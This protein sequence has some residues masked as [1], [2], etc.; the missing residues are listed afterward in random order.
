MDSVLEA[1]AFLFSE[2]RYVKVHC[3]FRNIRS[4]SLL[5]KMMIYKTVS[6][7]ANSN[8]A[9]EG[10]VALPQDL[11]DS[12]DRNGFKEL[13]ESYILG[14]ST[15]AAYRRIKNTSETKSFLFPQK[16]LRENADSQ[17]VTQLLLSI[18]QMYTKFNNPR[19]FDT[20]SSCV[21]ELLSNF[22]AHAT[23]ESETLFTAEGN[24]QSFTAVIADNAIGI[25]SSL[26]LAYPE[27]EKLPP[28]DVLL[29]AIQK[30]ISSKLKLESKSNHMGYG[31]YIVA[32]LVKLNRGTLEIWSEG[33]RITHKAGKYYSK[34]TGYWK[35]TIIEVK[36]HLNA[37]RTI[38]DI[39]AL[40]CDPRL[41]LVPL[42]MV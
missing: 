7:L 38:S 12:L 1:T 22:W 30:S 13:I 14:K 41:D 39:P 20:I 25:V 42:T 32:E 2:N 24:D 19:A 15:Q 9:E 8:I 6:H 27:F 31:L 29:K 4:I 3:D 36:L 40:S 18:K 33:G 26:K 21:C 16:L 34:S 5:G 10:S 35:G 23:Q 28:G 11:A 37:P 17:K